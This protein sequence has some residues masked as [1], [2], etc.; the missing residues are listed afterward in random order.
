MS[1]SR[2]SGT[3]DCTSLCT[4]GAWMGVGAS[5]GR[6]ALDVRRWCKTCARPVCALATISD[7]G[8]DAM[9]KRPPGLDDRPDPDAKGKRP[10]EVTDFGRLVRERR[11]T[12]G[13]TNPS[14][15][16]PIPLSY[17]EVQ[18]RSGDVVAFTTVSAVE[19]GQIPAIRDPRRIRALA[20]ALGNVSYS[21]LMAAAGYERI[22]GRFGPALGSIL[23]DV[24]LTETQIG[25][26][27]SFVHYLLTKNEPEDELKPR[28]KRTPKPPVG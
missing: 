20:I 25:E 4:S 17:R 14:T 11:L 3:P 10:K 27:E 7:Y 5:T 21:E 2:V 22:A 16:E 13:G 18:A 1:S 8:R 6:C 19:N 12:A 15:G 9:P 24:G 26:V 23:E 28:R